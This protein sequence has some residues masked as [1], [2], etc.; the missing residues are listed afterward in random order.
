VTRAV[1]F[2]VDGVLVHG[3]HSRPERQRRWDLFLAADLGIDPEVFLEQFIK[4][5]FVPEVLTGRQSLINALEGVLPKLGYNGSPMNL[6]AYWMGRDTQLNH[7][8]LEVIK[9]LR[10]TGAARVYI[11]TNQEDVR[12]YHLW[13]NLGLQHLFDDIFYAARLG[14]AKPDRKFFEAVA[15]R[16]GPQAE[17]PLMF[18]D[19]PPVI[20]AANAFGW[21]AVLFD[22]TK[23]CRNHTWISEHIG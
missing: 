2:D 1:L 20:E 10:G 13:S 9:K 4:P 8:L 14:A 19:Y 16:L 22:Q 7:P 3:Y 6:I 23:D 12:A 17:P 18:D 5:V 11:A 15:T 21:E